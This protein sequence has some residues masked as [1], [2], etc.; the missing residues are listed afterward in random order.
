MKR[1]NTDK[2]LRTIATRGGLMGGRGAFSDLVE[3]IK[4]SLV[5]ETSTEDG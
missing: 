4:G 5:S 1:W 2:E 3:S